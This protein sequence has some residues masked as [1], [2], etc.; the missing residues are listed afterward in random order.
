MGGVDLVEEELLRV[1]EGGK[2]GA[3]GGREDELIVVFHIADDVDFNEELLP[4]LK[5]GRE[6]GNN[7]NLPC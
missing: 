5:G 2:E 6:G 3:R 1:L 4:E 7:T